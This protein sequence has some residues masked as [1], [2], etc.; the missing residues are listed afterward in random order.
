MSQFLGLEV[1]DQ[2]VDMIVLV[3]VFSETC[4]LGL[5]MTILSSYSVCLFTWSSLW[6]CLCLNFPF[7]WVYQPICMNL[8]YLLKRPYLQIQSHSEV[9]EGRALTYEFW[10]YM[11]KSTSLVHRPVQTQASLRHEPSKAGDPT[12]PKVEVKPELCS[13]EAARNFDDRSS[14]PPPDQE[15][16]FQNPSG[17]DWWLADPA[18]D[19]FSTWTIIFF[20]S[21]RQIKSPIL[22]H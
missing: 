22:I 14:S 15:L 8:F 21:L 4:L 11:I 12:S 17:V 19:I 13:L 3:C 20:R 1:W 6:A 18:R 10:R 7:F 16:L 2:G 9:L 5:E